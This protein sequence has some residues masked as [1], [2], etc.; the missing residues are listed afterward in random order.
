MSEVSLWRRTGG[1]EAQVG[2]EGR[3]ARALRPDDRVRCPCE[4][5]S[6]QLSGV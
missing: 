6:D 2:A 5:E 1:G 3:L 4:T